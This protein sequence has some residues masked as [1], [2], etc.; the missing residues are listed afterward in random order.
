[1][2]VRELREALQALEAQGQGAMDVKF[3]YNYGDHWSTQVAADIDT[4]ETGLV[5]YSEYHSM[6]KVNDSEEE[7][8]SPEDTR[9]VVLLG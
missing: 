4:I 8:F 9:C 1:M 2:N 5:K 3:S 6:D 7:D